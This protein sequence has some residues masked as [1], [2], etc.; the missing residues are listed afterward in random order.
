VVGMYQKTSNNCFNL[1]FSLSHFV[2]RYAPGA[3]NAPSPTGT[4]IQVKQMLDGPFGPKNNNSIISFNIPK[5][6][7]MTIRLTTKAKQQ[8]NISNLQKIVSSDEK[9]FFT[10][11]NIDV[12][13]INKKKYFMLTENKTLFTIIKHAKGINNSNLFEEYFNSIIQEVFNDLVDSSVP[14]S[15]NRFSLEYTGTENN[16]VRRAQ[17]DHL[18]HAKHLVEDNINTFQINRYP[19]A[20]IGFQFPV[21]Y[22][23]NEM[24]VLLKDFNVYFDKEEE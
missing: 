1:I 20:S 2:R 24:S 8:L 5:R 7:T 13:Y 4:K 10:E 16:Y 3:Q 21:D 14:V 17:I 19:I 22:F 11:W 18:Y 12:V 9:K 23:I 15:M 6:I